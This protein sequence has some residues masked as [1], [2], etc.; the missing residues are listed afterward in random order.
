MKPF[1]YSIWL[2]PCA[3][4]QTEL[5]QMIR[6]LSVRYRAPLFIPHTTLCSG[7]WSKD[8]ENLRD[9]FQRLAAQTAPVEL[10]VCGI[11][12]TDHWASFFFLRLGGAEDFFQRAVC[13]IEG[14][15][16]SAVGPHLSLLY[17]LDPMS[18]DRD[19][20]RQELAG[21]LPPRIRFD[22]LA[23]VRPSTGR[24]EDVDQWEIHLSVDLTD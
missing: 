7:V 6:E 9:A 2:M 20:L 23:L 5:E 3:E 17:G 8:E 18:I 1:V 22:S 24:W 11:D 13:G 4:Q 15:H 21:W 16:L 14:A 12:W 10:D 19:A